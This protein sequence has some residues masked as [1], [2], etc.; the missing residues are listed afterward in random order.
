MAGKNNIYRRQWDDYAANWRTY[1]AEWRPDLAASKDAWP[2]DE[3]GDEDSWRDIFKSMFVDHGVADWKHCVEIGAGSGKYTELVLNTSKADVIAFDVSKKFIEVLSDRM[4]ESINEGRLASVLLRGQRSNEMFE[5]INRR[6]LV[7][8]IDAMYSIDAMVHVDLQYLMAYLVTAALVLKRD[9]YLIMT[10]AN[11]L[12]TH[13]FEGLLYDTSYYY[14][15]QGKP[16][17][18]F[19]WLSVDLVRRLLRRLG[20]VVNFVFPQGGNHATQ[21][22]MCVVATLSNARRTDRLAK[23]IDITLQPDW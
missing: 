11:A 7:R 12:S 22:D 20:F 3:W 23:A 19:E 1:I 18:K 8:K 10:L 16:S 14:C 5:E 2:G 13:G 6:G 17:S 9:G 15:M 21:R 4:K